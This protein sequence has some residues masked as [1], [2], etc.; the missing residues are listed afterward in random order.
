MQLTVII[1]AFNEEKRLPETLTKVKDYLDRQNY[2]WEVLVVNDGSRDRTAEVVSK[3]INSKSQ[4]PNVK[5]NPKSKI[6]NNFRLIDNKENRGKGGVVKQGMLE[7]CGDW[8]LFMDADNSTDI[9][10]IQKLWDFANPKS[11]TLNPKQIQNQNDQNYEIVIGSRYLKKDS[12]KVKQPFIR[13]IVSRMGNLLIQ[14]LLSINLKD[15]QCGFK[16]FYGKAVEDIFPKQTI[17]RWGFD[18]EILAIARKK[19]YKIKE[20]AVDWYDSASTTV[21]KSAALKTLK[22]LIA[23]KWNLI[24]GEYN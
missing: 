14:I 21:K 23:I 4:N 9:S 15:T 20:V 12:I 5:Q 16:L 24:K 11:E 19:G 10:E 1:P 22:E 8:R 2:D 18:M 13:R 3:W 7:A 17:M 6:Q